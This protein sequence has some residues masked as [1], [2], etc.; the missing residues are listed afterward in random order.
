VARD[1]GLAVAEL[2]GDS[3][4][5]AV[6]SAPSPGSAPDDLRRAVALP[7]EQA[8]TAAASLV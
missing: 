4:T 1:D 8:V 7:L 6:S 5:F 3:L 2:L